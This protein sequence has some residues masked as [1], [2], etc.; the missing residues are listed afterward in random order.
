MARGV[1]AAVAVALVAIALALLYANRYREVIA[2]PD[3]QGIPAP[4]WSTHRPL[5]TVEPTSGEDGSVASRSSRFDCGPYDPN[6]GLSAQEISEVWDRRSAEIGRQLGMSDDSEHLVVAAFFTRHEN[7]Q[8]GFDLLARAAEASSDN[9]LVTWSWLQ[10]CARP[11]D[12]CVGQ[13]D[14]IEDRAIAADGGNAAL[15]ASVAS[16]RRQRGDPYG[17]LEALD[18][19]ASSPEYNAYFGEQVL[20]Y[21]RALAASSDMSSI[22]RIVTA[23]GFPAAT[24]DAAIDIYT[25]CRDEAEVSVEWRDYCLRLGEKM[26]EQGRTQMHTTVG[27]AL[28][29]KMYEISNDEPQQ[30]RVD[31]IRALLRVQ[32]N[33]RNH[34]DIWSV[35]SR[36]ELLLRA[37]TDVFISSGE[38]AAMDFAER[39]VE[40]LTSAPEFDPCR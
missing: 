26:A 3:D 33:S 24:T 4:S 21:D 8:R 23:W 30:D 31:E 9:P 39:E 18:I 32:H 17:A 27:L 16:I 19:A 5:A 35:F 12:T 6:A 11:G 34:S 38:M 28:Q 29:S 37:Y 22:D 25:H 1:V 40:R 10:F 36:D 2:E 7:P 15:W 14:K 13:I 20:M